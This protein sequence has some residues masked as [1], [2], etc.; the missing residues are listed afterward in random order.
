MEMKEITLR[1]P[2]QKLVFFMELIEYLGFE[3]SEE[4]D[5]PMEH[6]EAVRARMAKSSLNP[7]RLLDWEESQHNFN[8]D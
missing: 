7:E 4:V 1:I 2:E 5:I 3:V 6:K 8:E